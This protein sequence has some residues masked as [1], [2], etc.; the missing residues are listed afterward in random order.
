MTH[1]LLLFFSFWAYMEL[2]KH[3]LLVDFMIENLGKCDE[4]IFSQNDIQSGFHWNIY[5][6]RH[7]Y[8]RYKHL[9]ALDN[10][11]SQNFGQT[12]LDNILSQNL[13][14]ISKCPNFGFPASQ[15]IS[16]STTCTSLGDFHHDILFR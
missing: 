11:L 16:N 14:H 1:Q 15:K 5:H 2:I 9:L 12:S 8:N 10:I 7:S 4:Q 6:R 3:N 13:G